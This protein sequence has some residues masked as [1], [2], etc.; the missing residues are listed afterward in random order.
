MNLLLN[1]LY[2]TQ[3]G[4]YLHL[5]HE[6]LRIEKEGETLKRIPLHHLGALTVFGNVLISPQLIARLLSE[7]K[8]IAFL[9]S[10]GRF[11]G[12]LTG[13]LSGNVLLR[14]A[15]H[16]ALDDP[17]RT[18]AIARCFVA[19]KLQNCRQLL[20]R[21]ARESAGETAQA[22]LRASAGEHG[23]LLK[24]LEAAPDLG[25]VRGIE[26]AAARSYFAAFNHM[27]KA[28]AEEFRFDGRE[29]RPPRDRMNALLSFLYALLRGDCAA[30]LEAVGLDPQVGYLHALRPGRPALALDLMEELRPVL[31]DK[32]ALTLVN[33][34]QLS[35][36]DFE[37][38][39]GEAVWLGDGGRRTVIVAYQERKQE[40]LTHP[41][42]GEKLPYG[43]VPHAQA[44]LLARHVRGDI[45]FYPAY[46]WR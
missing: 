25:T 40:E 31:A 41:T 18:L 24:P 43:L 21:S 34:K 19:G 9:T 15:Q 35:P 17:L 6:T 13:P 3:Q 2:V 4:C 42:L 22:A 27:V 46:V 44:R 20:L 1:T 10:H 7:G 30:A 28:Q 33:R 38:Q 11:A 12:R 23:E 45:P 29:R 37:D 8:T 16:A 14:R 5:D 32:L 26:G 36:G 39:P